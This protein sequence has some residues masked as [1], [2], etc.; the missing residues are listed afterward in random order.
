[1]SLVRSSLSRSFLSTARSLRPSPSSSPLRS[2][3]RLSRPPPPFSPS[4][5]MGALGCVESLLP[6]QGGARLTC[7]VSVAVRA[8]CELSQGTTFRR[9]CQDR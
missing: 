2:A 4:R 1:M 5:R 6:V 9:T 8:C 3:P 7:H